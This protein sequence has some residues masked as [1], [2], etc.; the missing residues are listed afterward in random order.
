MFA[1]APIT[2]S[3]TL[4]ED[5][6]A[7]LGADECALMERTVVGHYYFAHPKDDDLGLLVFGLASLCNHADRPNA[8]TSYRH[9][10]GLG[11]IVVLTATRD[12]AP[13]E[14]ITRRYACPPW[15]EARE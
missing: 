8:T 9:D 13:G 10:D 7:V 3:E 4:I 6:T 15:F 12:I 5:C 1:T 2:R 11:W 14:E